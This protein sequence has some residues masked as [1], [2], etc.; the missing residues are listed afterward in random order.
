MLVP[1]KITGT[2]FYWTSWQSTFLPQNSFSEDR[3]ELP[4][5]ELL[6]NKFSSGHGE[7]L[8]G[9]AEGMNF[10]VKKT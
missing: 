5:Q 10:I 1:H 4:S 9:L 7:E 3:T 6:L 2:N 8:C